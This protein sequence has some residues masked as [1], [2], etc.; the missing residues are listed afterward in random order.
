MNFFEILPLHVVCFPDHS[1]R[2]TALAA[3][4]FAA[5]AE[6]DTETG[7]GRGADVDYSK[8]FLS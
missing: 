3:G 8:D 4:D 7:P 6:G 2:W 1:G 5:V